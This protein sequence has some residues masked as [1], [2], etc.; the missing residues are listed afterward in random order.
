MADLVEPLTP[1]YSGITSGKKSS[2]NQTFQ[3][4]RNSKQEAI[5]NK[6]TTMIYTYPKSIKLDF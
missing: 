1:G 5:K 3:V 2:C 4:D 6:G